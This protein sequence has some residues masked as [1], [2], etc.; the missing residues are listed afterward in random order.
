[1]NLKDL[2]MIPCLNNSKLPALAWGKYQQE[3]Y[4]GELAINNAIIC[5]ITSGNLIVIDLDDPTL[6]D[7]VFKNFEE[8]KK[9]TLVVATGKKGYHIYI[10]NT[11]VLPRTMRLSLDDGRHIDIQSQGSYVI[12]PNSIHPDTG[13]KYEIVSSTTDIMESAVDGL[14]VQLQNLGFKGINTGLPT[15]TEIVQGIKEGNRNN[16]AFKYCAHLIGVL[17][18]PE[19]MIFAEVLRWNT[20]LSNPLPT[21]ELETTFKSALQRVQRPS[22]ETVEYIPEKLYKLRDLG[23][24][25]EGL[26]L[27]FGA[28]IARIGEQT[29][30]TTKANAVCPKCKKLFDLTSDG[31]VNPKLP[32]CLLCNINTNI[33]QIIETIDMKEI[34][35][36]ELQEEA[37]HNNPLIF[38]ARIIGENINK[39]GTAQRKKFCATFK[40][41]D[42]SKTHNDVILLIKTV[43]DLEESVE[44]TLPQD[45]LEEIRVQLQDPEFEKKFINSFAPQIQGH[46]R[47]KESILYLA[48]NGSKGVTKRNKIHIALVGNK[49]KGKSEILDELTH[50]T[51]GTYIVGISATKAGLGTGMVKISD[52]T[53]IS[54]AGPL[55]VYSGKTVSLDELDKMGDEDK[56]ALYD[57]MEQGIVTSAKAS[58]A[59][60][61]R[62][63]ADTSIL[64]ALNFKFGDWDKNLNILENINLYPALLSRF[65]LVWRM[66]QYSDVDNQLIASKVLGLCTLEAPVMSQRELR[67][68]VN[69]VKNLTPNISTA[70]K[71]KIMEFFLRMSK[72]L[73]RVE[74]PMEIRQLHDM[75]RLTTA[76]AKMLMHEEATVEDAEHVIELFK[77]QLRSWDINCDDTHQTGIAQTERMG[78][79]QLLLHLFHESC[80][81]GETDA[82]TVITKWVNTSWFDNRRD[83]ESE[84]EKWR[85]KRRVV[86]DRQSKYH[87]SKE[88]S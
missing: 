55:V 2:N 52:G 9:K 29:S 20:S 7:L 32:K 73:E 31:Y 74:L 39:I 63:T 81:N 71:Q 86:K 68:F 5:G 75:I 67:L 45:R 17:N 61:E 51:G 85:D 35:L 77:D 79:E 42:V 78:K 88:Y 24:K 4:Q 41:F 40:S 44:V 43:E 50:I 6:A 60:D 83:A 13:K 46:H 59:G 15:I 34:Y 80:I 76:R 21:S 3:K 82:E 57:C 48:I 87:L 69:S 28:M 38:K 1:M 19:D 26:D 49:S 37:N 62:L 84:L 12:A 56:K 70:G 14:L 47:I 25:F 58:M 54:K 10:R 8:L 36:Q 18:L 23:T 66:L 11:G 72:K 65:G 33:V 22:E 53:S 64:C 16:C 27:I 30:V